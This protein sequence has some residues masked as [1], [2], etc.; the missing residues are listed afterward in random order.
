MN[1]TEERLSNCRMQ[2]QL[3]LHP[4]ALV[5]SELFQTHIPTSLQLNIHFHFCF[6][7]AHSRLD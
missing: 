7:A 6:V 4:I 5:C 1:E 3:L 2:L